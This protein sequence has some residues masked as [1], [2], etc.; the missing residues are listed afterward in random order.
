MCLRFVAL[1]EWTLH[2]MK[3]WAHIHVLKGNQH[4]LHYGNFGCRKRLRRRISHEVNVARLIASI[5]AV[6]NQKTYK[7]ARN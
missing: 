7:L 4:G 6:L 2:G 5:F 3:P 1:S